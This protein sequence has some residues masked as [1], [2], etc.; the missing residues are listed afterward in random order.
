MIVGRGGAIVRPTDNLSP[1]LPVRL[2]RGVGGLEVPTEISRRWKS[3]GLGNGRRKGRR[4]MMTDGVGI[5][6][7]SR[8]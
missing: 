2:V 4:R 3:G 6:L 8:A 5:R 1:L 7:L